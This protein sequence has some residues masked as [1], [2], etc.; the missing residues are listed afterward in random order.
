[1][2]KIW[3]HTN[4]SGKGRSILISF[5]DNYGCFETNL[6]IKRGWVLES[7]LHCGI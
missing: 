3:P 6:K 4:V 2:Q 7:Q 1:M 5:S